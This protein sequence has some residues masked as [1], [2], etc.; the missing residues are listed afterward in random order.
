MAYVIAD[1]CVS[2]CDGA[3]LEQCPVDCIER[4]SDQFVIDPARCIVCSMCAPLCPVDAIFLE[5]D[6]PAHFAPALEKNA[7][8]FVKGGR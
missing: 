6:L 7:R 1:P 5:S 4:A 8:F 2:V 3:C